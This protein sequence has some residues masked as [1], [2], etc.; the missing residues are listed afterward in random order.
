MSIILIFI[1]VLLV[2]FSDWLQ[3]D[4]N[5]KPVLNRSIE[6]LGGILWFVGVVLAFMNYSILKALLL[7]FVSF[8]VGSVIFAKPKKGKL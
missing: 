2:G 8:V 7:L 4:Q 3:P 1:G 6:I 5:R